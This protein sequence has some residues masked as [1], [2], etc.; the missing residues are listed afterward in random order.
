MPDGILGTWTLPGTGTVHIYSGANGSLI[1]HLEGESISDLFGSSVAGLAPLVLTGPLPDLSITKT[2]SPDPVVVGQ[3]VTYTITITNGGSGDATAVVLMDTLSGQLGFVTADSTQGTVF[4]LGNTVTGDLGDIG[5]GRSLTVTVVAR[6]LDLGTACNDASVHTS[7]EELTLENNTARV[8]VTIVAGGDGPDL[9]ITKTASPDPVATGQM[10]AYTIVVTNNGSGDATGVTVYDGLPEHVTLGMV[11]EDC[12]QASGVVTCNLGALP[13]GET[14]TLGFSVTVGSLACGTLTNEASARSLEGDE[15]PS[16]NSTTVDTQVSDCEDLVDLSIIKSDFPDP[17]APGQQLTYTITVG[18]TGDATGVVMTDQIPEGTVFVPGS[19]DCVENPPGSGTVIWTIG[20]LPDG[21]SV[22]CDVTVTVVDV[23]DFAHYTLNADFDQGVMINVGHGGV[24]PV[25]DDQLQLNPTYPYQFIWIAASLRGTI[26]K[27]DTDTGEILGEYLSAPDGM[28]RD[29]SRT[30][31]D[32]NGNVWAGNREEG[33]F[34]GSMG[35]VVQIGLEQNLQ[36]EDRNGNGVIDTYTGLGNVRDWDNAGGADTNGGVSTAQDECIIKYARTNGTK[37][38][39]VSVAGNNV[40]AGGFDGQD[41]FDLIDG[42]TG[43]VLSTFDVDCGGY[44]GLVDANGVLWSA[45]REPLPRGIL[46]YDTKNT[47]P[48]A[49]DTYECMV[50][51]QAYGVGIDSLGNIWLSQHTGS[52]LQIR[53]AGQ[54]HPGAQAH[55]RGRHKR[56]CSD[57]HRR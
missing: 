28:G 24:F 54:S 3:D 57:P 40:W 43:T 8:C 42:D 23:S 26:I 19:G 18:T 41:D 17:V 16:D 47:T 45:D 15:N 7:A 35:S 29:P 14:V 44:G 25:P 48:T 46:R 53:S 27:I 5:E 31:V 50:Y 32:L 33:V 13:A 2:A 49:D 38:R 10:L 22:T 1:R 56:C 20:D 36:C 34:G 30:T 6:A 52:V 37:V 9:T 55:L 4:G 39:H 12:D 51:S 11:P 21:T